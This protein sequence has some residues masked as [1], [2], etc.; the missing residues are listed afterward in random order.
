MRDF[1]PW[2]K[3]DLATGAI[4]ALFWIADSALRG[5]AGITPR[6][7]GFAAGAGTGVSAFLLHEWG[8]L[9][10][11]LASGGVAHPE[12]RRWSP[13]LFNFDVGRSSRG[14]FIAMSMGGFTATALSTA[15]ILVLAPRRSLSGRV[16]LAA[17]A[18]GLAVTAALELPTF[19]RV[20]AGGPLP[21]GPV[22][23][24]GGER[25]HREA[26]GQVNT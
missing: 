3:R 24:S 14:Q 19:F 17:T 6:V 15:A 21:N 12:R 20:L 7:V 23:V 13:F 22:Y 26:D 16:A 11:A 2:A 9:F 8:H 1:L 25:F 4:T 18:A 5:R 10:G